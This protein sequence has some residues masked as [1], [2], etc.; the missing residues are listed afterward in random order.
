MTKGHFRISR[1]IYLKLI[2]VDDIQFMQV[3]INVRFA[4][5]NTRKNNKRYS[6]QF[7]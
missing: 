5:E 6:V 3:I 1:L 2:N 7:G 4:A